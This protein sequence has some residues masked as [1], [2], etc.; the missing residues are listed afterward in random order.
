[1]KETAEDLFR[2]RWLD[3]FKKESRAARVT[4]RGPTSDLI[5]RKDQ[6][7]LRHQSVGTLEMKQATA[8][9]P[10]CNPVAPLGRL[11]SASVFVNLSHLAK[12]RGVH[13]VIAF[14]LW[15]LNDMDCAITIQGD[16]TPAILASA[17]GEA[18]VFGL[19]LVSG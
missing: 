13:E 5:I 3:A 18:T 12:V 2:L 17:N 15:K 10:Y 14:V 16:L 7:N 9:E 1:L 6:R 19:R 4:I 8:V 11:Q